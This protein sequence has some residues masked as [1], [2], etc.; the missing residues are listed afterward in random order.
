MH[1]D[2]T[3]RENVFLN[4]SFL[5]LDRRSI[6]AMYDDIVAFAELEQ[7]ID[8]PVKHYSSG[9]FMRLGFAI[10]VHVD[11]EILLID[12]VLAVA[13]ASFAAKCYAA[14]ARVKRRGRTMVLV[15]HDPIQV[16]RFCDRVVWLDRGKVRLAGDPRKV[17]Q[18][19]VQHMQGGLTPGD[20]ATAQ[21]AARGPTDLRI[22]AAV[23]RESAD[24]PEQYS[25]LP[26]DTVTVAA[27]LEA[28]SHLTDVIVGC[29][30]HRSDG[31][32]VAESTTEATIGPLEVAP[33]RTVV[34]CRLGPAATRRRYLQRLPQGMAGAEA[35]PA[36][37]LLGQCADAFRGQVHGLPAGCG[38][39]PGPMARRPLARPSAAR[40]QRCSGGAA[41]Y[42]QRA[43]APDLA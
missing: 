14:L 21:R 10:A 20:V 39:A 40:A 37:P 35:P 11:P 30:L 1:P 5:G 19:Y 31:L 13:D 22:R 43:A 41:G 7:F 18:D 24:G 4:G 9:M 8:T 34:T 17:I 15:S 42:D 28:K 3:G 36:L 27:E 12:E 16:R 32:L 26:G 2:L 23:L 33:G 25:V 29:A 38:R 6:Q